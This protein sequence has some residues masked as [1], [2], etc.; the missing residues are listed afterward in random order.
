M[1]ELA[2]DA[3]SFVSSVGS[4]RQH[5]EDGALLLFCSPS[6]FPALQ[7]RRHKAAPLTPHLSPVPTSVGDDELAGQRQRRDG[8]LVH[9][10]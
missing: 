6:P 4:E 5:R 2:V 7:A 10:G 8:V 9:Q 3:A 1:A